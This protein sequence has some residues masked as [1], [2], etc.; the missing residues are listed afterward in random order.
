M[1]E[2]DFYGTA[3]VLDRSAQDSHVSLAI[4]VDSCDT[5]FKRLTERGAKALEAPESQ[6]WGMRAAY[7][8]GPGNIAVELE[9]KLAR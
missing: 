2:I 4:R 7:L 6:P 9:E 5:W 1:A 3:L 8:K